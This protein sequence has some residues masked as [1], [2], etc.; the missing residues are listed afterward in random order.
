MLR[1]EFDRIGNSYGC[2]E[3]TVFNTYQCYLTSSPDRLKHDMEHAQKNGTTF[4]A[5][6]VRG[7]YLD[8]E[9]RRAVEAGIVSPCHKTKDDTDQCYDGLAR[10]MSDSIL[11]DIQ[12]NS[13]GP[14]KAA[15]AICT[16][17]VLSIRKVVEYFLEKGLM[18]T[19]GDK[20]VVDE[21][22]RGRLV[23]GQLMGMSDSLTDTLASLFVRPD[24]APRDKPALPLVL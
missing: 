8:A 11:L 24:D 13:A 22:L 19:Q 9:N 7:A 14:P 10:I 5:K 15:V 16:N 17:N 4:G 12:R 18:K 23:F 6:L 2:D 3:P 21:R 1:D 20:I